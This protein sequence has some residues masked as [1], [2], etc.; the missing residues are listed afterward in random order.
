[1]I[2][3][4]EILF[5]DNIYA[6]SELGSADD[7]V[8]EFVTSITQEGVLVPPRKG[9]TLLVRERQQGDDWFDDWFEVTV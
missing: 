6:A 1:M 5:D 7:A 3:S 2:L 9:D 8:R 4:R